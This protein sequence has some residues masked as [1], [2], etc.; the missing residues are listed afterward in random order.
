MIP[1]KGVSVI[2]TEGGP[3]HDPEADAALFTALKQGL[4]KDIP[5]VEMANRINDPEFAEAAARMLI[6]LMAKK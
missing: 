1:A 4:R 2:S 3:F 6:E 5:V